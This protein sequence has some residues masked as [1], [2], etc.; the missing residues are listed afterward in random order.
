MLVYNIEYGNGII[1]KIQRRWK[2][3]RQDTGQERQLPRAR[4]PGHFKGPVFFKGFHD[5]DE[6]LY[7]K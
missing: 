6:L 1:Y 7:F 3:K 4:R 5:D 2:G